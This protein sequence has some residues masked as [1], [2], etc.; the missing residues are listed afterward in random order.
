MRICSWIPYLK[1]HN[2]IHQH[3]EII[4]YVYLYRIFVVCWSPFR[5]GIKGSPRSLILFS[6]RNYLSLVFIYVIHSELLIWTQLNN[7]T[8]TL[9]LFCHL[10]GNAQCCN[11][12]SDPGKS[13]GKPW[14][15]Y[16][17]KTT[18][19]YKKIS[20][21]FLNFRKQWNINVQL[22]LFFYTITEPFIR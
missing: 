16:S 15:L 14:L 19:T 13:V 7:I 3:F 6:T 2:I 12:R 17:P 20:W 21:N 5:Y 1:L 4:S 9:S 8:R 18:K 10:W 11:H 22:K